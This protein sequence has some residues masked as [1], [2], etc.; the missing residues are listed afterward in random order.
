L[1]IR[2]LEADGQ[3]DKAQQAKKKLHALGND[4]PWNIMIQLATFVDSNVVLAP[5]TILLPAQDQG[6]IGASASFMLSGN[7]MNF[8]HATTS[9]WFRYDDMLYQDLNSFAIRNIK[10]GLMHHF[11]LPEERDAWLAISSDISTLNNNTFYSGFS[12]STGLMSPLHANWQAKLQLTGGHRTFANAFSAFSAW[13][14]Q[15]NSSLEHVTEQWHTGLKLHISNENTQQAEEAYRDTRLQLHADYKLA[16]WV[17]DE[18]WL[19][20]LA[21]V[22]RLDYHNIDRRSFLITPLQRQDDMLS[23]KLSVEWRK[24]QS[25]WGANALEKWYIF[26]GWSETQSNMN[27]NTV[28]NPIQSR[29][30]NRWWT[31]LGVTW[32]Y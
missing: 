21:S 16:T 31:E 18:L 6:D 8:E 15:V 29:V 27:Q 17:Q 4:H 24:K 5:T 22:N 23:T 30:W 10:G 9:V 26:A 13:R 2:A 12:V 11:H 32:N 7:I 19:L 20:V 1:L 14:W 25:L 28:I 3:T